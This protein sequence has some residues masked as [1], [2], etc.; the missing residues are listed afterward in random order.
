MRAVSY[1]ESQCAL[2]ENF[3]IRKTIPQKSAILLNIDT[4]QDRLSRQAPTA[5]AGPAVAETFLMKR[6]RW[7]GKHNSFTPPNNYFQY[8]ELMR[9][10]KEADSPERIAELSLA[11]SIDYRSSI[12]WPNKTYRRLATKSRRQSDDLSDK[13]IEFTNKMIDEYKF[14]NL[15][16]D[17]FLV[18]IQ[19]Q[20]PRGTILFR[21]KIY[22]Q[23]KTEKTG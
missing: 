18:P 6:Q 9:W 14:E 22:P 7:R 17:Q 10:V 11:D 16:G 23:P 5:N 20:Q 15:K 3:E 2:S 12:D 4:T 1:L 21:S 8:D 13:A 19:I